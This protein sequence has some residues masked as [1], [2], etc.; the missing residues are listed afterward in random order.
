MSLRNR[1]TRRWVTPLV[2]SLL[3]PADIRVNFTRP[4]D[5]KVKDERVF[6]RLVLGGWGGLRDAYVD[7]EWDSADLEELMFRVLSA[8]LHRFAALSPG[9][10]MSSLTA[11]AC[12]RLLPSRPHLATDPHL[13]MP[14]QFYASFLDPYRQFGPGCYRATDDLAAAPAITSSISAAAGAASR[15]SLSSATGAVSRESRRHASRRTTRASSRADCAWRFERATF[16]RSPVATTRSWCR[17][18]SRI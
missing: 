14:F 9:S 5:L 16:V 2:E 8:G 12:E 13:E 10:L 11:R 18:R 4:W 6:R 15:A 1:L 17:E 3:E 7:G